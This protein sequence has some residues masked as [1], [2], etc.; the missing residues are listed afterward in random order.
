MTVT[1]RRITAVSGVRIAVWLAMAAFSL[2]LAAQ[3]NR[4][5][6]LWQAYVDELADVELQRGCEP[7]RIDPRAATPAR[8]VALLYH[9]FAACPQEW[10]G[11][12]ERL[13]L[14]GF[15]VLMPVLP[16]HG[17]EYRYLEEGENAA[18]GL[19]D[20]TNWDATYT[21]LALRMN[22][23]MASVNGE[24]VIGGFSLGGAMAIFAQLDAPDLYDRAL[25]VAPFFHIAGGPVIRYLT[26]VLAETPTIDQMQ[27]RFGPLARTCVERQQAGWA[28]LC[29]YQLE[30]FAGIRAFAERNESLLRQRTLQPSVQ[31]VVGEDDPVV[32]VDHIISFVDWHADKPDFRACLLDEDAPHVLLSPEENPGEPM[33]WLSGLTRRSLDFLVDGEFFP[34]SVSDRS[35]SVA[36]GRCRL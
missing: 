27:V 35:H 30:H 1:F 8:G 9:G 18:A 29:T 28:G 22:A 24:R 32:S 36:A 13:S 5:D 21:A 33:P 25:L 19:P 15:T 23:V 34:D 2:P 7:V 26:G 6:V 17:R 16:G 4:F 12:G 10:F 20:A 11:I 3:P 14:Q 31:I